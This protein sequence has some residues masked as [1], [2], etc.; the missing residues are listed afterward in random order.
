MGDIM[1][2]KEIMVEGVETIGENET[3]ETALKKSTE[4]SE[5]GSLIVEKDGEVIGIVTTWDILETIGANKDLKK[6]K[7]H[8][9]METHLVTVHTDTPVEK[10]AKEMV[11]HGIWRLPVEEAGQIVGIVSA[12]DILVDRIRKIM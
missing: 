5:G 2:V 11:D 6:V 8:D 10:A 4:E 9:A 1:E 12:T 7:V 3:L